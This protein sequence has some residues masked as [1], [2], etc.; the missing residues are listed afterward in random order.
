MA[1]QALATRPEVGSAVPSAAPVLIELRAVTVR[2]EERAIL[3]AVDLVLREGELVTVIGPNGAG[4]TTL[5]KVALGLVAPSSGTV[6]RRAGLRIGYAPQTLAIDRA[7][8]LDVLGFL[9]LGGRRPRA[10]LEAVLDE[11]GVAG[12]ERRQMRALSGGELRRV[13][14]A[15]ALLRRPELLVLDE[16]LSGV[17]LAGQLQLY[18]LIGSVRRRRGCAVLLV[19]HDLHLVMAD[20]DRVV[21]LDRHVCCSGPPEQVARDAA[22]RHLLGDRLARVLALYQ[23]HHAC[24]HDGP[25]SG[26]AP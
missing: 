25:E 26:G 16:P 15:R 14:L 9:E 2:R 6:R 19:S 7:M 13:L 21:C 1:V 17:D 11:V 8:P 12:L 20:T 3:E 18:E 5:V 4:K 10:E 23:H 22:F 24:R